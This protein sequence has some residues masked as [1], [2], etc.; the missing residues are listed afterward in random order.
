M[1][2]VH[3]V[4]LLLSGL[5]PGL[6]LES[7]VVR[8]VLGVLGVLRVEVVE[9]VRHDVPGVHG[10]PQGARDALH[11]HIP[12]GAGPARPR[13]RRHVVG[14]RE[15]KLHQ[16]GGKEHLDTDQEVLISRGHCS[17]LSVNTSVIGEKGLDKSNLLQNSKDDSL[18]KGQKDDRFDTDKLQRWVIRA[19]HLLCSPVEQEQGV[20]GDGDAEVVDH[21]DGKVSGTVPVTILIKTVRLEDDH[22]ERHDRFDEA[23]LESSLLA[24][25]QGPDVVA[26]ARQAAR[27]VEVA[28][29]DGPPP[30]LQ[31]DVALAPE[32]FVTET[33]EVVN[34]ESL[35][36]VSHC[37]EVDIVVVVAEE[38]QGEPG[39]EGV[40]GDNEQNSDNPPLL[41]WV[42]VVSA[43]ENM[44]IHQMTMLLTH[45]RY[46]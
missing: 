37:V 23:E 5:A 26:V 2:H 42:C 11:G 19:Q 14:D 20:Q 32:I 44:H 8:A 46:W 36:A 40:N 25:P 18:P 33:Q 39:G 38:K 45:L 6:R 9:S 22:D 17:S 12:A 1:T 15:G 31:Q 7:L 30:D 29:L 28:G 16:D 43:T 24:E 27:A 3:V 21:G 4:V 41:R 34:N 35:V 13:A 10:L